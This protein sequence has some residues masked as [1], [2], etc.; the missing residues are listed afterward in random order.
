M[1]QSH[2]REK[3]INHLHHHKGYD[4][5]DNNIQKLKDAFPIPTS[6]DT[7]FTIYEDGAVNTTIIV[8]KATKPTT[9]IT[10]QF[11]QKPIPS[12]LNNPPLYHVS[13]TVKSYKNVPKSL[14]DLGK[15]I[16]R[17]DKQKMLTKLAKRR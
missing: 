3:L 5:I 8:N 6:I 16:D 1:Q 11:N 17:L 2:I 9:T 7:I 10:F 12:F 4:T 14:K 13:Q 15:A